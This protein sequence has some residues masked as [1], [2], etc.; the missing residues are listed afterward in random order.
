MKI[1]PA[2]CCGIRNSYSIISP[3]VHA[4]DG[5][6]VRE[7]YLH[8][9]VGLLGFAVG[10]IRELVTLDAGTFKRP[11]CIFALLVAE[12]PFFAFISIYQN[13]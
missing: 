9:G 5:V 10:P 1:Q 8:L 12:I 4:V 6:R 13:I 3:A 2:R 11:V 7:E